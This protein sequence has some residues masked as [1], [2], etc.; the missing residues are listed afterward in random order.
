MWNAIIVELYKTFAKPRT[1]IGLLAVIGIILLIHIGYY[2][3]KDDWESSLRYSLGEHV[4]IENLTLNGNTIFYMIMHT[5]FMQLNII[6]ALVSGDSVSGEMASGTIRALMTKP[7]ARWKI[8]F[9]KFISNQVY[10]F[11]I[12]LCILIFGLYLSRC[13]FGVGDI[14]VNGDETSVISQGDITW[15]FLFSLGILYI[16]LTIISSLAFM[17]SCIMEN[18]VVPIV[19]TIVVIIVLTILETLPIDFFEPMKE[20]LFTKYLDIWRISFDV[21]PNI[22]T[23]KKPFIILGSYFLIF[24]AISYITFTRKDITQ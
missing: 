1:Y 3:T 18:S 8:F 5:L 7:I 21:A 13:F 16:Y 4:S 22:S 19:T 24:S 6:I 2:N 10:L 11:T 12:V 15:R 20:Y 23:L 14:I 9:A 17:F